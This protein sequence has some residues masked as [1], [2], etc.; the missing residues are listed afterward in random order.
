M[1]NFI[2]QNSK[3]R[4]HEDGLS[5]LNEHYSAIRHQENLRKMEN[6][7]KRLQFEEDRAHKMEMIAEERAEKMIAA[8]NRHF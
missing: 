4:V 3:R 1:V 7:V 6:R 8:R 5:M 2:D